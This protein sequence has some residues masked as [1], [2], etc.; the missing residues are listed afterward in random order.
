M[1]TLAT[2]PF[3]VPP[4]DMVM[5]AAAQYWLTIVWGA[6]AVLTI[7]SCTTM[8]LKTKSWLPICLVVGSAL[9]MFG[10][11][12]VIPNMNYW[13][14]VVG[15]TTVYR[16]YG[17]SVP[18]FAGL[19]YIFYFAPAIFWLMKKYRQGI[20]A[21][22]FWRLWVFM[23]IGTIAYEVATVGSGVC[24]Y[25]GDQYFSIAGL[26]LLWPTLNSMIIMVASVILYFARPY[27]TGW[28]VLLVI[29]FMASQIATVEVLCGY[30]AFVTNNADVP[31]WLRLATVCWAFG[32][33]VAVVWIGSKLVSSPAAARFAR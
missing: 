6:F 5:P 11:A 32:M 33:C 19:A 26:P 17:Q 14:P 3:A 2:N 4:V 30:P 21:G 24:I 13:Y 27:L 18:L 20:S 15:Q 29:P 12:M 23:L 10:E 7:V 22:Q 25:Y 8:S 16:A 28:R 9:S 1:S 31:G